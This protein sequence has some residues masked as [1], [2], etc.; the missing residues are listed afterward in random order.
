MGPASRTLRLALREHTPRVSS[1]LRKEKT[2]WA[3]MS[4]HLSRSLHASGDLP[5]SWASK[6]AFQA[7]SQPARLSQTKA[8][9]VRDTMKPLASHSHHAILAWPAN[10]SL[11]LALQ[12]MTMN[13]STNKRAKHATAL[14]TKPAKCSPTV[15]MVSY[16][17]EP[18]MLA[19][20]SVDRHV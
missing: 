16:A 1:L 8:N 14:T 9:H 10:Q 4:P 5:A 18:Q 6:P 7:P 3:G 19:F 13:V 2:A 12:V 11:V 15:T 20:T 17:R